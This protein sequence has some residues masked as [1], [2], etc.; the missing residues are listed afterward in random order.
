MSER[1]TSAQEEPPIPHGTVSRAWRGSGALALE[2]KHPRDM[3][4]DML[5][6]A[7]LKVIA[8]RDNMPGVCV[9]LVWPRYWRT[10]ESEISA[11]LVVT[12]ITEEE[13]IRWDKE[14]QDRSPRC[15]IC[16][17]P[18]EDADLPGASRTPSMNCEVCIPCFLCPDC[19]VK[20]LGVPMCFVCIQD[21]RQL[22]EAA[23]P[24]AKRRA[25][26]VYPMKDVE[27]KDI[28]S[29]GG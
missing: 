10:G 17:D 8:K 18:C 13:C 12:S 7:A 2:W 16:Y 15:Y 21:D 25:E 19:S 27:R 4:R 28:Q 1:T 9:R 23:P 26:L 22:W 14:T 29:A 5:G 11:Q 6:M 20:A 3:R 24:W